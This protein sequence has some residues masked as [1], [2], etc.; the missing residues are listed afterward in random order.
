M[1]LELNT[2]IVYTRGRNRLFPYHKAFNANYSKEAICA[3]Q[4]CKTEID[5]AED[6][7]STKLL[8]EQLTPIF[9]MRF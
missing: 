8:T 7:W 3:L 4:G 1:R 2:Q 9:R 5:G 6:D